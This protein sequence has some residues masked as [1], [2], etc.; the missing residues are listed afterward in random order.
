MAPVRI[1]EDT[2]IVDA[3]ESPA[4]STTERQESPEQAAPPVA[5]QPSSAQPGVEVPS[6][7]E[8][9]GP[10]PGSV[11][12]P[13]S[14]PG[15]GGPAAPTVRLPEGWQ[16]P[17]TGGSGGAVP[18]AVQPGNSAP[19]PGQLVNPPNA[20][21]EGNPAGGQPNPQSIN[22]PAPSGGPVQP[23]QES[24]GTQKE[25]P[26]GQP[27]EEYK[28]S[29]TLSRPLDQG[30]V[31]PPSSGN[32]P[33]PS[34]PPD[35][36]RLKNP[37]IDYN[38]NLNPNND[39]DVEKGIQK[40]YSDYLK[41]QQQQPTENTPTGGAAGSV[42]GANPFPSPPSSYQRLNNPLSPG[43]AESTTPGNKPSGGGNSSGSSQ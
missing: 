30:N 7:P 23:P 20:A 19:V 4:P 41:R 25:N 18:E 42:P 14:A 43:S 12:A 33:F 17:G 2:P 34:P 1:V 22:V 8:N 16:N 40:N 39:S 15:A 36:Q 35:Y 26:V 11:E 28:P 24:S 32:N 6:A 3:Y 5:E 13:V 29:P 10:G 31:P 38:K 37:L 27:V 9:Q 21:S